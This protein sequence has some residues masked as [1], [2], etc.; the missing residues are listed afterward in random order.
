MQFRIWPVANF[1]SAV[2]RSLTKG[3]GFLCTLR[4]TFQI[5]I[6]ILILRPERSR[7]D[8]GATKK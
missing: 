4:L 5:G 1:A 3:T 2:S 7:I 6:G 8:C